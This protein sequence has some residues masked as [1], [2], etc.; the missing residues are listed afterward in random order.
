MK[1]SKAVICSKTKIERA[2]PD[3]L[4]MDKLSRS[5]VKR[6]TKGSGLSLRMD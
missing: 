2:N 3:L 5:R 6:I 1:R 4:L